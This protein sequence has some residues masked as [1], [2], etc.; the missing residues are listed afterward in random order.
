MVF[1]SYPVGN[2]IN[3]NANIQ[4]SGIRSTFALS[5]LEGA[6]RAKVGRDRRQLISV[7]RMFTCS[8]FSLVSVLD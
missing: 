6:L 2:D 8:D 3:R 5:P 4:I 7:Q 1:T